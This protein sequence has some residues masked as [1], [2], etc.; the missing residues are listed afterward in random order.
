MKAPRLVHLLIGTLLLAPGVLLVAASQGSA[1]QELGNYNGTVSGT[2]LHVQAG[3]AAFPNFATGAV[4]NRYPLAA[5]RLDSSPF[6][7]ALSSPL[8]TGPLGQTV[9]ASGQQNQP[10]YADVR[11]PAQ[12]DDKPVV[13]GS[14]PGPYA[15]SHTADHKAVAEAR[16]GGVTSGGGA[17]APPPGGGT[18][19]PAPPPGG[20]NAVPG[21]LDG[22]SQVAPSSDGG[23]TASDTG[24]T[25]AVS[26][27]PSLDPARRDALRTALLAWRTRFLTAD[28]AR[29][30]PMPAADTPDGVSG[31][32]A[33]SEAL[34]DGSTLVLNGTSSVGELVLGGGAL[35]LR[36]VN[37]K[38]SV[39]ND[40]T[41]KKTVEIN[42]G[43]ALVGGTPVTIGA[44][45]V[46]VNSQAVPGIAEAAAQANAAL[47]QALNKAGIE[48]HSLGPSEQLTDHQVTLDAVGVL[49]RLAPASPAPGVPAN[50]TDMAVGEVFADALAVPGEGGVEL[51]GL[52]GGGGETGSLTSPS[53][54]TGTAGGSSDLTSAPVDTGST[55]T[56]SGGGSAGGASFGSGSFGSASGSSSGAA[57]GSNG[58]PS[59]S[60]SARVAA[61]AA[62][63]WLVGHQKPTKLLLLY[64]LWQSLV[65]G[66]VASL[67]LWRKAAA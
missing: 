58:A 63:R 35:V 46:S 7:N 37:V 66:T 49:I 38:V 12:C 19:A 4:D 55:G 36:D 33:R 62:A 50:F 56:A 29:R 2:A 57:L 9:A 15:S 22:S 30:Y 34:L 27:L 14:A 18:P 61:P 67:Y 41:P 32:T 23:R 51:G 20:G 17:P 60:P 16:A 65:I 28:D 5:A 13:I 48:V 47:N 31:D 26:A 44:G 53:T 64:L 40:G 24:G 3:S 54:D 39:T 59:S 8:D 45:G 43:S 25:A 1:Q 52:P 11:C 6:A 42:I 10:Q 21:S